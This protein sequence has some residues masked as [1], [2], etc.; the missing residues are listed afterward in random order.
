MWWRGVFLISFQKGNKGVPS[1]FRRWR[2]KIPSLS[3]GGGGYPHLF[4]EG[5]G[6]HARLVEKV[7]SQQDNIIEETR[8]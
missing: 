3:E 8:A 5:G 2:W 1:W 7:A 6:E 4:R